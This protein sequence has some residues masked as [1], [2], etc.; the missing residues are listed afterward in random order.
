[1]NNQAGVS[2]IAAF[3]ETAKKLISTGHYDFV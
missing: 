2:D 3:L 1:M